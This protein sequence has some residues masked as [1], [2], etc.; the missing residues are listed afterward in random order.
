[1]M[2]KW[3]FVFFLLFSTQLFAEEM[4]HFQI[5]DAKFKLALPSSWQ[6]AEGMFGLPHV[7]FASSPYEKRPVVSVAV[8]SINDWHL[9]P[10]KLKE[11]EGEYRAGREA[12]LQ[13]VGGK[14]LEFFPYQYKVISAKQEAHALGFRYFLG[15][16][17]FIEKSIY[18]KCQDQLFN[19]KALIL[20][21]E[22]S[23]KKKEFFEVFESFRCD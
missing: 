11:N 23:E 21:K 9:D 5:K 16:N 3:F 20:N 2:A 17:E 19:V 12:W 15:E 14:A 22:S 7:F 6:H 10:K 1:M 8:T 13:K 4:R 18:Y